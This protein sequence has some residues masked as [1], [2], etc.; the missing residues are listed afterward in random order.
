[1][2]VVVGVNGAGAGYAGGTV[3]RAAA[4]AAPVP[5]T[6]RARA[7]GGGLRMTLPA[8]SVAVVA[9]RETTASPR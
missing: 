7:A 8:G 9:L 5:E 4:P 1:V 3:L 6:L 2:D